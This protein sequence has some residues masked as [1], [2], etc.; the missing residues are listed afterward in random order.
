MHLL[1]VGEIDALQHT[2]DAVDHG[3]EGAAHEVDVLALDRRDE[4]GDQGVLE[5]MVL[6]VGAVLELVHLVK[7]VMDLLR[8]EI[9]HGVGQELGGLDGVVGA[10]DEVVVIEGIGLL[11]HLR[12]LSWWSSTGGRGAHSGS[13]AGLRTRGSS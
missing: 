13:G 9:L 10:R 8:L 11:C 1:D 2:L 12:V 7:R 6:H 5:L 4:G 3:V